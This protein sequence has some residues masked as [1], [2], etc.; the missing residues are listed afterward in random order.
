MEP[1]AQRLILCL[2]PPKSIS[3]KY[4]QPG[5]AWEFRNPAQYISQAET[6]LTGYFSVQLGRADGQ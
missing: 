4:V 5:V 2:E 6:E 1:V 3:P